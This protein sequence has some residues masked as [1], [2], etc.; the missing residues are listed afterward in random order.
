MGTRDSS[1]LK[2]KCTELEAHFLCT[3]LE[4]HFLKNQSYESLRNV[5]FKMTRGL[6][7]PCTIWSLFCHFAAHLTL[8]RDSLAAA[9]TAGTTIWLRSGPISVET[10]QHRCWSGPLLSKPRPCNAA[11]HGVATC[12]LKQALHQVLPE[13]LKHF[14]CKLAPCPLPQCPVLGPSAWSRQTEPLVTLLRAG[15]ESMLTVN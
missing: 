5:Y 1:Q 8:H 15:T 9:R 14:C 7:R 4:A 2:Q 6:A 3:E 11:Q 12:N 13:A 10:A